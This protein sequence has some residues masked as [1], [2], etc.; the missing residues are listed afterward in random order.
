MTTVFNNKRGPH[1]HC[2]NN[3]RGPHD[4]CVNN[5]RG[6]H[7]HCVNNKRGPHDPC[8]N[9]KRGP[10]DPRVN[11]KRGPHDHGVQYQQARKKALRKDKQDLLFHV[12]FIDEWSTMH[13]TIYLIICTFN[14]YIFSSTSAKCM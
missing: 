13:K 10:H 8:V 5:K 11:N 3:K 6:P 14:I 2:V 1:D 9:H 12:I 7:D 4:P